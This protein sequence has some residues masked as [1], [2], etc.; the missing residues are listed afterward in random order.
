MSWLTYI[1]ETYNVEIY[2]HWFSASAVI[3]QMQFLS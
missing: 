3:K 1:Y 2:Y